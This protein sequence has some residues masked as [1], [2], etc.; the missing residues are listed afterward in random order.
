MNH[1][2]NQ[3]SADP[4]GGVALHGQ[5]PI[6]SDSCASAP[7]SA[8][9]VNRMLRTSF[10][11][12]S[13]AGAR[14]RLSILIF[15]RVLPEPDPLLPWDP[16]AARFDEILRFTARHFNVLPLRDAVERLRS[17]TLP[18]AAACITFDDG[19]ADNVTVA[20]PLLQ[21][22]GI[23]ATFFV[24]SAFLD[25]GRM[26][27]DDVIE[28]IRIAPR[29]TLDLGDIGLA[30]YEIGDPTSRVNCYAEILRSIKYLAPERRG[31]VAQE[32]A[33]RTNV[34]TT[35]A[36]MMT[37]AQLRQLHDAGFE[38]G[39]HT[40]T[41]PILEKLSD[42]AAERDIVDGKDR[43]ESLLGSRLGLF[44]YPNGVPGK[45]YSTRHREMVRRAGFSAAVSTSMAAVRSG[46]D[47]YQLPRFL[48]WGRTRGRFAFHWAMRLAR[49]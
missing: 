39:G 18:A 8:R 46:A 31:E 35:P 10:R 29:G 33:R 2:R 21:R 45:D 42:R 14:A 47:V 22:Y 48:P 43:L 23:S 32:I 41:H 19:Y 30:A 3:T 34:A 13:P 1:N 24:A 5:L 38:I 36:L 28:A 17:G 40:N 27:N 16:D 15:H 44:A 9:F 7:A 12:I 6:C 37:S 25:G 11:L 4:D 26:W 20:L 49:S